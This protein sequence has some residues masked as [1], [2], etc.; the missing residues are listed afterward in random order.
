MPK[1][2]K[3]PKRIKGK[4]QSKKVRAARTLYCYVSV[5]NSK[6]AHSEGKKKYGSH[7]AYVDHLIEQDRP[8]KVVKKPKAKKA[9]KKR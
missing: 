7:S 4:V 6:Y 5:L 2:P 1:Q 9:K 3:R 8:K